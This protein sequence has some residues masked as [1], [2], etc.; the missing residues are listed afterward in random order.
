MKFIH[1]ADLHLDQPFR[2]LGKLPKQFGHKLATVNQSILTSIVDIAISEA[3]DIV[4]IVG[5]TFHQPVPTIQTQKHV[6]EALEKLNEHQIQVVLTFGNHDYYQ[7]EKYWF[8]FPPNTHCIKAEAVSTITLETK[9]K[10]L[11]AISG[12]SYERALITSEM[13]GAFPRR[14]SQVDYHLGLYHGQLGH[15]GQHGYA[16]FQLNQLKQYHYD[17]WALGHIHQST[18]LSESPFVVYP[19]TPIGHTK[20]E[21]DTKGI[22]IANFQ[23]KQKQIKW[24]QLGGLV[25]ETQ[26]I[27]MATIKSLPEL[28]THIL[29][30]V[31][32][33]VF[34]DAN[35]ICLELLIEDVP[36][37]LQL[38]L[39]QELDSGELL[40]YLQTKIYQ[41]KN[42]QVWLYCI[43]QNQA[44]KEKI[45]WPVGLTDETIQEAIYKYAETTLFS[46]TLQPLFKQQELRQLFDDNPQ[47][48]ET[49]LNKV[50]KELGM[51]A[52]EGGE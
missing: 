21:T 8:D 24:Q 36:V 44:Q 2:G 35:L 25:W 37:E 6:I 17:Y 50:Q 12:F 1:C 51:T 48:I 4:L 52:R 46:T 5:D 23:D 18:I 30:Q 29:S 19:G 39:E 14:E 34:S 13:A 26:A 15:E 16:P 40:S 38:L 49:T 28:L 20:K 9:T 45:Q 27:S 33:T 32:T 7:A 43:K 31:Q 11:V 22:I 41:G 42:Q 10:E 3:V 47:F